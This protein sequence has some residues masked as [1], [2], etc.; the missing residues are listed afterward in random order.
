MSLPHRCLPED[1]R[2]YVEV[3][4]LLVTSRQENPEWTHQLKNENIPKA[5][6]SSPVAVF[7][8]GARLVPR[9]SRGPQNPPNVYSSA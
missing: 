2:K 7:R 5:Y 6:N 4:V 1:D 9:E 8:T 3:R